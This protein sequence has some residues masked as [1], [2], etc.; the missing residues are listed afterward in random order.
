[1]TKRTLRLLAALLCLAS[2]IC[3]LPACEKKAGVL[4]QN[5]IS[6]LFLNAKTKT[7]TATVTVSEKILEEH[8]GEV[9]QLYEV[10]PGGTLISCKAN[11]PIAQK[12]ISPTT[13]ITF[14]LFDGQRSRMYSSFVVAFEDGSFLSEQPKRIQNP[15]AMANKKYSF[16]WAGAGKG[17]Y[18]DDVNNAASL[19]AMHVMYE[20][21][22]A[23]LAGGSDTFS[24]GGKTYRYSKSALTELDKRIKAAS[25]AGLQVSLTLIPDYIP[26]AIQAAAYFDLLASHY[27]GDVCGTVSAFFIGA[28]PDLNAS[29]AA[30]LAALANYALL[31]RVSNGRVY[32]VCDK[33]TLSEAKAFFAD[34]K[35]AIERNGA[36]EWGAAV[37]P[38]QTDEPWQAPAVS[39][40]GEIPLTV[41]ALS[42][43]STYL[44]SA[45]KSGQASHFAV[46]SLSYSAE[47]PDAQA[48]ALA[49]S[50]RASLAANADLVF[51]AAHLEDTCG[52]YTADGSPRRAAEIFQTVDAKLSEEN[53]ALVTA[54]AGAAWE[55][56]SSKATH[57]IHKGSATLGSSGYTDEVWFDF[58]SGDTLGF[59]GIGSLTDPECRNSAALGTKVLYTWMEPS[60]GNEAGVRK[61]LLQGEELR[62][63]MSLTVKLLTQVPDV[64]S[65]RIRLQLRGLSTRGTLL[66]HI[67]EITLANGSWQTA[68]F[69][70]SDFVAGV[71][72]SEPCILSLTCEP[73]VPT[74]AEYVFW[75][76]SIQARRPGES[77]SQSLPVLL[78]LGGALLGF[79]GVFI[80]HFQMQRSPRPK[81]NRNRTPKRRTDA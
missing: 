48:A 1:M 46:T 14:N 60:I 62:G 74:D 78:I 51:Y 25:D 33:T 31:S 45:G 69:Q 37:S 35:D 20:L 9:L 42:S 55:S 58:S 59:E 12:K 53:Q 47:D 28:S 30:Q 57:L 79:L 43:L 8:A 38:V 29:K 66:T 56:L 24:F 77:S 80:I 68:T 5:G 72:F 27:T 49:Y 52:L 61:L 44:F 64:E 11:P 22:L 54:H 6:S 17:L 26:A 15:Q 18:A 21:S 50:Y 36:F 39:E 73:D 2:L 40:L 67:S 7:V 34:V 70:I 65:C 13:S 81:R 76:H 23:K 63:T 19:G 4:A 3:L 41:S 10:L 71:D 32:I 16:T 75:L